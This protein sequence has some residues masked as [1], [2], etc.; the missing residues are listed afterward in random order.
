MV[1][2]EADPYFPIGP[3][4]PSPPGVSADAS[5]ADQTIAVLDSYGVVTARDEL[6]ARNGCIGTATAAYAT[7]YPACL[8]YTGCPAAYPVVWC[9]L[10]GPAGQ[11]PANYAGANYG[12]DSSLEWSFLSSLPPPP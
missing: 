11:A 4:V 1:A 7:S 12:G 3:L 10:P 5:S 9:L 8:T 2:R 6:L